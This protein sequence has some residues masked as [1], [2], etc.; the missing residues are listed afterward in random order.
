ML[1]YTPPSDLRGRGVQSRD[2][3]ERLD[4]SRGAVGLRFA[5]PPY[6]LPRQH[7]KHKTMTPPPDPRQTPPELE[8]AMARIEQAE[9]NFV[10]LAEEMHR[11]LYDHIKGMIGRF[12]QETGGFNLYVR[13]PKDRNVKGSPRVLVSQIAENLR[14]ALDYMIF[15]LSASNDPDLNE[16]LPQFVIAKTEPEFK[17]QARRQLRYL[18]D[19]QRTFVE[20]LQPY[21]GNEM[22]ALLGEMANAGKHRSLL[23]IQDMTSLDIVF[24]TFEQKEDFKDYFVYP[25]EKGCAVF[26]KPMNRGT[27]LLMDGY[28]A[29]PTLRK[30]IGHVEDVL[31]ISFRFFWGLPVNLNVVI[32]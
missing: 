14:T 16:R 15:Q 11:F 8:D 30:I 3:T 7:T 12:D 9:N 21:H 6:P 1:A 26:A 5:N 19:E 31:R 28:D 20:R 32:R 29:M 2:G 17:R 27:V 25:V 23:S 4:A 24:A 10:S 22:L 13:H 18:T